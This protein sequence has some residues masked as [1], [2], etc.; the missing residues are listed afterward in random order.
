MRGGS[1]S[2]GEGRES[3]LGAKDEFLRGKRDPGVRG[4]EGS[5]CEEGHS[6]SEGEG[7]SP[8]VGWEGWAQPGRVGT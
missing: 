7:G 8:L 4:E 1:C 2:V 3:Q 6:G 5:S